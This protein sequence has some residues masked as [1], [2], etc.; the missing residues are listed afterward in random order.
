MEMENSII[1]NI[2]NPLII[3][4]FSIPYV[5]FWLHEMMIDYRVAPIALSVN[6]EE[7]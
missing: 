6:T 5:I 2:K 7:S 4:N 1:N 3:Y